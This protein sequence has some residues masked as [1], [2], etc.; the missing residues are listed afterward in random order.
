MKGRIK[1][2]DASV[3]APDGSFAYYTRYVTGGQHPLF[4][5]MPRDGGHERVLAEHAIAFD[6]EV[7]HASAGIRLR[8]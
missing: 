1:E 7:D 4:C 3:P 2:D 8:Y 5:R 6:E